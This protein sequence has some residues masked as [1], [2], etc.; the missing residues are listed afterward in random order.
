MRVLVPSSKDKRGRD[1][2]ASAC[3]AADD[4]HALIVRALRIRDFLLAHVRDSVHAAKRRKFSAA[5]KI[6]EFYSVTILTLVCI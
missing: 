2:R 3:R 6:T 5:S 1:V 4:V